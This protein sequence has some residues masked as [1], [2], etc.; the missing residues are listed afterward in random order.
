M[1]TARAGR[2]VELVRRL[3]RKA[4][5]G[6]GGAHISTACPPWH[7]ALVDR[8]AVDHLLSWSTGDRHDKPERACLLLEAW[9]PVGGVSLEDP[10]QSSPKAVPS[11]QGR[12]LLLSQT[13]AAFPSFQSQLHV[14]REQGRAPPFPSASGSGWGRILGKHR[15]WRGSNRDGTCQWAWI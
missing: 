3:G 1:G 10:E 7:A 13:R 12:V 5:A 2:E 8:P 9:P 15:E 11:A 6:G 4:G 14:Q